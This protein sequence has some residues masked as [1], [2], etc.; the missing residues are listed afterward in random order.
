[1]SYTITTVADTISR[2][3]KQLYIPGIQRPYVWAPDQ[4][5][6]LFD[7][8][9]RKYPIGTLLLW[10]LPRR[11]RGDWEIYRFIENFR[12]GDIHNDTTDLREDEECVLVLDGQQRLTSML[13][14]LKGSYIVRKKHKRRTNAEAWE[15]LVLHLDL[16]HAPESEDAVDD[17]DSPLAEHYRFKFFRVD[18]RPRNQGG[19]LWFELAFMLGVPDE[20]SLARLQSTW[21][22]HNPSLS[23]SQKVVANANL[24]RLWETLWVDQAIAYFTEYSSSYD[25]VLDIFIR[26][27]DGGTRLSRSDLLMSVITL[28]W[29]QFNAREETEGMLKALTEQLNPKRVIQREFLLRSALYMNDLN[30]TIQVKNFTPT[31]IRRL[32]QSWQEVKEALLF[33]AKWLRSQGLYGEALS[34]MN[35]AMLLAYYFRSSG[36]LKDPLLLTKENAERVRQWVITLQFQ[37]LLS[38]QIN[39][40][41]SDFRNL[42]RRMPK[43]QLEFPMLEAGEMFSRNGREFGFNQ[44]TVNKFCSQELEGVEAEKLLSLLYAKDLASEGLRPVPLVQSRYFMP[45]ELRRAGVPDV[46]HP[47]LQQQANRL[48]LAVAL[49]E[50]ESNHYYQL[51]FEQWAQML[52]QAQLRKHHLPEDIS[53]YRLARLPELIAERARR[54]A[55]HLMSQIPEVKGG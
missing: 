22:D 5:I 17:E 20:E 24:R 9:M 25:R 4:V 40:T 35:L 28:R 15:D 45:E 14:G 32:E 2:I 10:D 6:R 37:R 16:A 42:I 29:E 36:I 11:S 43:G 34:G 27:N 21:I 1:M 7:S 18:E 13:I 51:P 53:L 38:L 8:L 19:E 44:D 33:T 39:S 26:A 49:D 23:E 54:I 48:L 50:Q 52:S 41:L 3:N 46:L 31:N 12:E 47:T 30:F 55:A